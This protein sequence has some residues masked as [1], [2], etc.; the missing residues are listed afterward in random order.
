MTEGRRST[1]QAI[2]QDWWRWLIPADGPASG[3]QRA[4]LAKLR[5]A[6]TPLEVIQVPEALRLVARLPRDPDRTAIL[7]GVLA[8]VRETDE[9]TV[10]KALG[11]KSLDDDGSARLSEPRFRRL[12]QTPAS[13]LMDPMR[14]LVRMLKGRANVT[15]LGF[16]ILYWGDGVKR[17]WIFDYYSVSGAIQSGQRLPGPSSNE[18]RNGD[19][20][21]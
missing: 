14:R 17:R 10:A 4:V 8:T 7:A 21:G 18:P 6:R 9:R 15:D 20:H 2:T 5:R 13:E 16:S 12:M 1:V 11:R 19:S 3:R